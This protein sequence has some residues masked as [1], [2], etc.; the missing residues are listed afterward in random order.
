MSEQRI[1]GIRVNLVHMRQR[2]LEALFGYCWDRACA[3]QTDMGK[4]SDELIR[5]HNASEQAGVIISN[6]VQ[7]PMHRVTRAEDDP[8]LE[9][10]HPDQLTFPN[11]DYLPPEDVA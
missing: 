1:N 10:V 3:A 4:V 9:S 7:F 5:R 2:Q 8:F 6:V 11:Q